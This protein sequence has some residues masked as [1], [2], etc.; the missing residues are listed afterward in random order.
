MASDDH[1]WTCGEVVARAAP[2]GPGTVTIHGYRC[3]ENEGKTGA[4]I[5]L[6]YIEK[7]EGEK[8]SRYIQ[9]TYCHTISPGYSEL[10][11]GL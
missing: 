2:Y 9:E 5:D 10:V 1:F 7:R 4:C 3:C 6:R 8:D 11:S